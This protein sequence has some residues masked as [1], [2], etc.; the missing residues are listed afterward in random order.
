M[1]KMENVDTA[2]GLLLSNADKQ[3]TV[4]LKIEQ[5]LKEREQLLLRK[6]SGDMDSEQTWK[7]RGRIA[8]V[9]GILAA[10][11]DVPVVQSE[12]K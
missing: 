1:N 5:H 7:M 6:L 2:I 8:E 4:W 3:S 10:G 11:E 9:S 12:F